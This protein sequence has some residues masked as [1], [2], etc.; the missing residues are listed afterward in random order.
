MEN[1]VI[2]V[3]L[4]LILGGAAL[5]LY[6]AKKKGRRCV[7]CPDSDREMCFLRRTRRRRKRLNLFFRCGE[8][9]LRGFFYSLRRPRKGPPELFSPMG[10]RA[11]SPEGGRARGERPY[12]GRTSR[13]RL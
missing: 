2:A 1:L 4:A 10:G 3:L 7:G 6:R 9:T 11:L 8:K 13:R 12:P 5:Y